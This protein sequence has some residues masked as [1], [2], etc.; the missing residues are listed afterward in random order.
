MFYCHS[1]R[2]H[3]G[4]ENLGRCLLA[5]SSSLTTISCLRS[6]AACLFRKENAAKMQRKCG[7]NGHA[8]GWFGWLVLRRILM[9][10]VRFMHDY[11]CIWEIT[12][13]N[14]TY[15]YLHILLS[16]KPFTH[17]FY[18]SC[19]GSTEATYRSHR[20]QKEWVIT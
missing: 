5:S 2:T 13:R 11:I 18:Y 16:Q 7:E 9:I 10:N 20:I 1:Y 6:S 4:C 15:P 3:S 14:R 17:T 19:G 12:N 8:P